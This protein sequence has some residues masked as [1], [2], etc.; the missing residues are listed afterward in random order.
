MAGGRYGSAGYG[1]PS[2]S[3]RLEDRRQRT[4]TQGFTTL[5]PQNGL[6]PPARPPA[7]PR[8][9]PMPRRAAAAS[10]TDHLGRRISTHVDTWEGAIGARQL[11]HVEALG[12]WPV[13]SFRHTLRLSAAQR[14]ERVFARSRGR[15]TRIGQIEDRVRRFYKHAPIFRGLHDPGEQLP[16]SRTPSISELKT[17]IRDFINRP[18]RQNELLADPASWNTLCSALDVIGDTELALEAY[19]KWERVSEDGEKYLLVHGALQVMEV[20]QDAGKF[21][22]ETPTVLYSWP[23]ELDSIRIIGN[24][25][26]CCATNRMRGFSSRSPRDSDRPCYAWQAG[27]GIEIELH[28]TVRH[29][30]TGLYV[31]DGDQARSAARP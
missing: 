28:P 14:R 5:H 4:S 6:A 19:L 7:P 26:I 16:V 20:Q 27:E 22:C 10:R 13:L 21:I 24:D 30:P 15:E 23:K 3:I 29:D 25:A 18:R 8:T 9:A 31:A 2:R 1:T 11:G 17:E 12:Y